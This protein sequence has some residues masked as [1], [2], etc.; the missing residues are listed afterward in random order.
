VRRLL[1]CSGKV[2]VELE[3]ELESGSG[4]ASAGVGTGESAP[5]GA[6]GVPEWLHMVRVERLYPFPQQELEQVVSRLPHLQELVWLQEEPRNMGAWSYAEPKLREIARGRADVEVL[7]IGRP[8]RSSPAEGQ[9]EQHKREQS[10]I[11][12][13]AAKP[14]GPGIA[15]AT[16]GGGQQRD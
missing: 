8:E 10:R 1:V 15:A 11:M 13:L 3:T 16:M 7:Y 5:T 2:A 14:L 6:T 4:G 9:S 12:R